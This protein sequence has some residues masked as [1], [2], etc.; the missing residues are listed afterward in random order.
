MNGC[1]FGASRVVIDDDV[2]AFSTSNFLDSTFS[3]RFLLFWQ[4]CVCC[5]RPVGRICLQIPIQI[6]GLSVHPQPR[7]SSHRNLTSV[8]Q[9]GAFAAFTVDLLV[10]PLDTLKTRIQAPN[11]RELYTKPDGSTKRALFRGLYQGVGSIIAITI[12]SSGAFFTTYEALKFG[13]YEFI[14]PNS[15]LY[16]PK[17]AI[18]AVA[19][20]GAE[21][22]S[23][24]ILTPAE[25]IKQNA[26]MV[27]KDTF[28]GKKQ[29][30]T[31]HVFRQFRKQPSQLFRGYTALAARNLPFTAMQFPVFEKLKEYFLA[32]RKARKGAPVDGIFERASITAVS[33]GLA[34]C[35][36][37]WITTPIDVV[38]TRIMLAAGQEHSNK[39]E[40]A[41]K[42]VLEHGIGGDRK[43]G[44]TVAKEV[45]GEQGV[46]GLFRGA[47]L[48]ASW[49]TVG[50]GLYLGCYEGGRFYLEDSRTRKQASEGD[51]LMQRDW[52]NV[53]VGVGSSRSQGDAIKKSA[54]QDD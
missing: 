43:S 4:D 36:A 49:T 14:P 44:F 38:K 23:C 9:A 32:R 34:G 5:E 12:P 28:G 47:A 13:L 46:R 48:R 50:A 33:G 8:L 39:A 3:S 29:S 26:Q 1:D 45:V 51:S 19:S 27:N 52:S 41:P 21:L 37:A 10:Y 2:D 54:W 11:Y 15:S 24:A 6:S 22:V 42:S 40:Q 7:S 31:A 18:H 30:P 25:V 53:Q 20:A 17:S 35:G 16:V